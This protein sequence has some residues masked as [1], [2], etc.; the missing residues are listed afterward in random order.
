LSEKECP[1]W[2]K[3]Y[4]RVSKKAGGGASP[5]FQSKRRHLNTCPH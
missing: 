1:V 4:L 2:S 3:T 5:K